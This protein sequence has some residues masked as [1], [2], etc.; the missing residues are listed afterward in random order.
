MGF[1]IYMI[2]TTA[3]FTVFYTR[4][5]YVQRGHDNNRITHIKTALE[6]EDVDFIEMVN[7]LKI[8]YDV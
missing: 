1:A 8:D 4:L 6:L 2:L 3:L 7:E 5:Q